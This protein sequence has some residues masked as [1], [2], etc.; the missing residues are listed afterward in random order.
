MSRAS[1]S[2]KL[3]ALHINLWQMP[4]LITFTLFVS[5]MLLIP[6]TALAQ[7]PN[8]TVSASPVACNSPHTFSQ[9]ESIESYQVT[10][11]RRCYSNGK[12]NTSSFGESVDG[13]VFTNGNSCRVSVEA[14]GPAATCDNDDPVTA[15]ISQLPLFLTSAVDPRVMLL[16]S[17]DHQL[18]IKAY[19]DYSD[20]NDDGV[21]DSTY[22]DSIS[23][24]GYFDSNKCYE[25]SSSRFQPT[26][27][28]EGDNL[29]E[30]P[31]SD[32]SGNFLNW[33]SMTRMDIIRKVLYGGYRSTDTESLTILERT[34]LPRD[35]HSF[36]KVFTASSGTEMQKYTPY[37]ETSI[38]LC[39]LT[40][41]SSGD[42]KDINTSSNPPLLRIAE[43]QWPQWAAA[44]VTQCQWGNGQVQPDSSDDQLAQLNV[45]VEVCASGLEENNCKLYPNDNRKP[46][47]IL[48]RFSKGGGY[49]PIRFGLM[50]GS[51]QKNK[52]G[53]VLRRNV[54]RILGN[55]D[56]SPLNEVDEDTGVFIN[57]GSNEGGI[58]NT[59]NRFRISSY[60]Y[61]SSSYQNS[62][63]SP[64]ITS[65]SDGQCVDWGNPL[66]EIYL[67]MLRYLTGQENPTSA[68]NADDGNYISG[69]DQV[70][71][72]DPITS[73]QW[74][75]ANH[76]IVISTGLNSFDTDQLTGHGIDGLDV[77]EATNTVGELEG[78]SGSYLVGRVSGSGNDLCTAKTATELASISGICPEVPNLQGG[79][80]IAG[81]ADF[82]RSSNLRPEHDGP[83]HLTTQA[84][85][86]AESLPEFVIPTDSGYIT[87]LPACQA[88][89][90]G[91]A[92]HNDSGWR[93][94]SMTDVVVEDM[95]YNA[96]AL[97]AGSLLVSWEDSSWGSDYDMDGISRIEFCRGP[98]ACD[99]FNVGSNQLKVS[100]SAVQANAGHA[101]RFG[102]TITGT[103][104]DGAHLPVLRP[105]GQNFSLLSTPQS[106]PGNAP[107]P[108]AETFSAGASTASLLEN[109]LWYAA[110][111][112]GDQAWDEDE[113]GVPDNFHKATNPAT[114]S[115]SLEAILQSIARTESTVAAIA[116]NSTRLDTET[117]IYQAKFSSADWSGQLIAYQINADGTIGDEEWSTEDDG[118]IPNHLFRKIFTVNDESETGIPFYWDNLSDAQQAIL[119]AGGD[120]N[121]GEERLDWLRGDQE[122]EQPDGPLRPRNRLLGDIINSDPTYV[123]VNSFSFE[124]LPAGTDGLDS[125]A[126]YVY[127]KVDRTP[128][129]YV[130]AND[131]MMHAFNAL[132]GEE[133]FAFIPTAVFSN[134]PALTSP[135]YTDNPNNHKY[136]VDSTAYAGDAYLDGAW[137]TILVGTTGAGGRS[138]FALDVTDPDNFDENDVLWEFTHADLGY[139]IGQ[140]VVGRLQDGTWAAIF[141]NGYYSDNHLAKLF[142]VN[143]SSGELI[144]AIDTEVG[145][146][147]SPNGLASPVLLA[148]ATR[149]I[150]TAYAGDKRG[151]L[152]KFDLSANNSSQWDV[153]FTQGQDKYPLFQAR[154]ASDSLQPI[155]ASVEIGKHPTGGY[156]IYFGTGKFYEVGDNIVNDNPP[157]QSFYGIWD[158]DTRIESTDRSLL[159]AQSIIAEQTQ[160]DYEWR[161]V[162]N[163][164][165]DWESQRGWYLDLVYPSD[166]P[167]GERVVSKPLLRHG[168][169]IFSTLIPSQAPCDYGG[170][171]WL[172]E[173]NA[174]TGGRLDISVF[175]V[176]E[177]ETFDEEDYITIVVDDEEVLVPASGRRSSVGIIQTP[178]VISAGPTEFKYTGGSSG[179][180]EVIAEAG[181]EEEG[182]GRRSWRQL[183]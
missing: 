84:V 75:A 130:G 91:S 90:S 172:M 146:V 153:A 135:D 48:Q 24:Y 95:E 111:Y 13:N 98:T 115:S 45:R 175:D 151:N 136:F 9:L 59:L 76:A 104:N 117:L 129:L 152:W 132:T 36:A 78:I 145:A 27:L 72:I 137:K 127:G 160:G 20:L 57:Q 92:G 56:N 134:L 180:I 112:G 32:W 86:L 138:V 68:F 97:V 166:Q 182:S 74:C 51:Y 77:I 69:L 52:S 170:T 83:V 31:G 16:M 42:S 3:F 10:G 5:F 106:N 143:L 123:G 38:S 58:I 66:S 179:E 47:G 19:T 17:N 110:K 8:I 100:V 15:G 163:N 89:S 94:C 161:A 55:D 49:H 21:I 11:F 173:L 128:M 18:Y 167:I 131:G 43:G 165:I 103:T 23:Y 102:Y 126:A 124:N 93:T 177:D 73:E 60:S 120:E 162:S 54:E 80:H 26:E 171:S 139:T 64:G 53:G 147:D 158:N 61:G 150:T 159:Q 133:V 30:C 183:Q 44:E 7:C 99:D 62:C 113:D 105:G 164:S 50:T 67:E 6:A 141:G 142:I 181:Q 154:N 140:P 81:L 28:A 116:T 65:F 149:T 29:H 168:R 41:A 70:D 14:T 118:A 2:Q 37:T 33:A 4:T 25:Y 34:L 148:D 155:S 122:S 71:W 119:R 88:N 107:A 40:Q 125:Y 46:V 12:C 174:D 85:A 121:D 1:R 35:V 101:L 82:A 79:Y 22:N 87:L 109:P 114:L 178:A 144:K 176:N 96:D 169:V 108:N 63:S 156:I 39:S 157:V